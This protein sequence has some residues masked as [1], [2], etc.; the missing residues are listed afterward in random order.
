M[1]SAYIHTTWINNKSALLAFNEGIYIAVVVALGL[2]LGF[3]VC[4]SGAAHG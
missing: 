3:A 1:R 2:L 4:C